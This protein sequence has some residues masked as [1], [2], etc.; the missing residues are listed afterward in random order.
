MLKSVDAGVSAAGTRAIVVAL[1]KRYHWCW[2]VAAKGSF[3]TCRRRRLNGSE[4]GESSM[5]LTISAS[6][7]VRSAAH[8]IR[9]GV[10]E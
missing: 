4:R 5:E 7:T 10:Q 2:S 8:W 3:V 6:D 9:H 1:L